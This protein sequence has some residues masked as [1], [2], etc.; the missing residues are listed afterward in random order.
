MSA[1]STSTK[2]LTDDSLFAGRLVCRQYAGGYRFSVDAVLL[3]HFATPKAG[4]QVLDLGCGCGVIGLILAYRHPQITLCG[5]ELQAELAQLA[6][7]N[8]AANGVASRYQIL[9][10]DVRAINIVL[11]PES[12]DLVVCNPPYREQA[13]G[14]LNT[15]DQAALAR[16]EVQGSLVDFVRAAAFA[17]KNRGKVFFIYPARRSVF[18]LACLHAQGLIPKRLQAIYSYPS[19]EQACLVL[20]EA[21]K[22]GGEQCSILPPFYLYEDKNGEQSTALLAMYDG[23]VKNRAKDFSPL[24]TT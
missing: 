2:E 23:F 7:E 6:E 11:A 10:S 9:N 12:F 20:V 14:R 4:Q 24:R 17:V 19:A 21:V 22:N 13:S 3:A 8:V 18:L 1:L 5:L 16:H 15:N